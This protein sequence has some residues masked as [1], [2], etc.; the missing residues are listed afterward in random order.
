VETLH[1]HKDISLIVN[2]DQTLVD[3]T[4]AQV[5]GCDGDFRFWEGRDDFSVANRSAV[6]IVFNVRR[7]AV[8][9]VASATCP[10]HACVP[11]CCS[12]ARSKTACPS[13]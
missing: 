1:A 13:H 3:Q 6:K 7:A 9:C 8:V 5:G 12:L 10:R 4:T 11:L 2:N